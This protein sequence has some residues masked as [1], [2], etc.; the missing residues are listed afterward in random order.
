M[1]QSGL[2]WF[3][4]NI[5]SSSVD[6]APITHFG[7][8]PFDPDAEGRYRC[9]T[10][11][12]HVAGLNIISELH[13]HETS[14]SGVDITM[15]RQYVGQRRGVLVPHRLVVVSPRVRQLLAES[16]IRGFEVEISHLA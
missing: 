6:V 1:P 10:S 12:G 5:T 14:Y 8:D 16:D 11:N 13:I 7:I 15:T 3:R 4:L 2:K 9:S